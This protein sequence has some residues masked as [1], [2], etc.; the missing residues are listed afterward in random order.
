LNYRG[1][2][3]YKRALFKKL[4]KLVWIDLLVIELKRFKA[5]RG[6]KKLRIY[7]EEKEVRLIFV[8]IAFPFAL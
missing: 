2:P 3:T 8:V 1:S 7:S 4:C 5:K 6:S